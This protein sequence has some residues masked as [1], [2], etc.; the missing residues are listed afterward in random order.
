ML[1]SDFPDARSLP[2][3]PCYPALVSP[4]FVTAPNAGFAAISFFSIW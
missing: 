2:H 3:V 1:T 4:Y